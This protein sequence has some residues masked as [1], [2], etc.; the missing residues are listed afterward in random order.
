MIYGNKF[1]PEEYLIEYTGANKEYVE[2]LKDLKVKFKA[3]NRTFKKCYKDHDKQG[4]LKSLDRIKEL[5]E[6]SKKADSKITPDATDKW[7]SLGLGFLQAAIIDIALSPILSAFKASAIFS[8]ALRFGIGFTGAKLSF[9]DI[10][11]PL[12]MVKDDNKKWNIFRNIW[13][14]NLN[15]YLKWIKNMK[16]KIQKEDW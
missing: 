6:E 12:T 1:L 16:S 15:E 3:E 7:I 5:C 10:L 2:L 11:N 13:A 8:T 14:F 4:C 9:P